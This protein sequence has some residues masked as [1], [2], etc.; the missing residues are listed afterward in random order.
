MI[1]KSKAK[2]MKANVQNNP[3]IQREGETI[4]TVKEFRYLGSILKPN[5][6]VEADVRSGIGKAWCVFASIK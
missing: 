4:E 3:D 1:S 5:G 6:G 2:V